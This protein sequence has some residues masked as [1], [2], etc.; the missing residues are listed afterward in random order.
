M[1][2][3]AAIDMFVV[4]SASFR[5]L[6]V[7]II[8]RHDRR[9]IEHIAVTQYPTANWLSGQ[10]TEAFP[11]DTAP[12]YLLRD[13]DQ[14]YGERFRQRVQAM[15]IRE[16]VTAPRSPWQ[17]PYVE[18][19]IGSI[20]R[21]CLDHIVVFN[22]RHLARV[23]SSYIEYYHRSRTHLS[24]DKDCRYG[25]PIQPPALGDIITIP[26]VG[27]CTIATNASPPDALWR[28]ACS[29]A[30]C[31]VAANAVAHRGQSWTQKF[32]SCLN[33]C[34]FISAVTFRLTADRRPRIC[35]A[36]PD[37]MPDEILSTDG[38]TVVWETVKPS[39]MSSP[40][41]RGAPHRK[42][43][44]AIRAIRWRTSL[45]TLGRPPRQRP[46]DRYLHREDQ[47]R[48]RQR[49]TVS[50]WTIIRLS[51]HSHQRDSRIHSSRS[52]GRKHG[53][54]VRLRFARWRGPT[55]R[56]KAERHVA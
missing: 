43:S 51:R 55:M 1:D 40:W 18:R 2:G 23:L 24:L 56:L 31:G 36:P 4:A 21:E 25:R 39:F 7:M 20:R 42:F 35:V 50:G 8:L 9:K 22:E 16:V 45:E 5:L 26:Q 37:V 33:L 17:N 29:D 15:G 34:Q 41:I 53:R 6:H 14:S 32:I 52:Q 46:R 3:I 48:R 54:G 13:R 12:R 38:D 28:A 27:A 19:V 11:W 44:R 30:G 49:K 10:V 47:P